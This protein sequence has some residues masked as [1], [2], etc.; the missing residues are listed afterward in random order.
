VAVTRNSNTLHAASGATGSL[1]IKNLKV[2]Y[3]Y[4]LAQGAASV[5]IIQDVTTNVV[6]AH[7]EIT[8]DNGT[9]FL[10]YSRKPIVF[11]NGINVATNTTMVVILGIEETQS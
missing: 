11:P 5:A 8:T 3:I 4:F 9:V 1:A 2:N 10:D 6:K 7:S